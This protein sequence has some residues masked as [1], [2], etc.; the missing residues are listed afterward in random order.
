LPDNTNLIK[1]LLQQ[2]VDSG[3][4]PGAALEFRRACE[5]IYRIQAGL[6][7]KGGAEVSENTL[8]DLASLTKIYTIG[9]AF[10]VL[11]SHQI[12]IDTPLNH[13]LPAFDTRIT[14]RHLMQHSSGLRLHIQSICESDAE[15]WLDQIAA[16]PLESVPGTEVFYA[17]TNAFLLGRVL[18]TIE[19][20]SLKSILSRTLIKPNQL[21]A[22]LEV[23]AHEVVAPTEEQEDGSFLCG[24]VHDEATRSFLKQ[25]GDYAGNSGLFATAKDVADF[26]DLWSPMH[27]FFHPEDIASIMQSPLPERNCQRGLGWQIGAKSWLSENSPPQI[28][29][30]LGFTGPLMA[31]DLESD[32]TLVLLCNRVYPNRNGPDRRELFRQIST[33]C[34]ATS[35]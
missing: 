16:A 5:T 34:F 14:L 10:Q 31:R 20:D 4:F 13:F 12:S 6:I 7:E 8:Y 9:M 21:R 11:R 23:A 25:T 22:T 27:G 17:C 1:A 28:L 19:G 30:H 15:T 32:V 24:I 18:V 29:S 3:M 26:C 2:G 33:L 35:D